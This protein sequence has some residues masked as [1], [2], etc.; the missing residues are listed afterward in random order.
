MPR[1]TPQAV[2]QRRAEPRLASMR[3][4]RNAP[5]NVAKAA[6]LDVLS[7]SFNEAGAKCPG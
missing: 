6:R 5:D 3:P 1:I 2:P 7:A 4:G